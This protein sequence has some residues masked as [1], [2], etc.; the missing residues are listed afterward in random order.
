[1]KFEFSFLIIFILTTEI[2]TQNNS[3]LEKTQISTVGTIEQIGQWN[4]TG[5][6][7]SLYISNNLAFITNNNKLEIIDISLPSSPQ[8]ISEKTLSSA[9]ICEDIVG[10]S[11]KIFL[12]NNRTI[13]AFDISDPNNPDSVA[14]I[15]LDAIISDLFISNNFLY[16]IAS[17]DFYILDISTNNTINILAK[18]SLPE[19]SLG[20]TRFDVKENLAFIA[21]W[22][23]GIFIVD[24]EDSQNP[25]LQGRFLENSYFVF[26]EGSQAYVADFENLYILDITDTM[27]PSILLEKNVNGIRND[28]IA[29]EKFLYVSTNE[30]LVIYDKEDLNFIKSYS[31]NDVGERIQIENGLIF[32]ANNEEGL[33]ILKYNDPTSA[34]KTDE[35]PK[36]FELEQNYPNPFNSST[37]IS[38]QV[39]IQSKVELGIYDIIGNKISEPVNE[40]KSAGTYKIE[41]NANNLASG[42]YFYR[43][44]TSNGFTTSK[45]LILIK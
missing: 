12:A 10:N 39:P 5:Q 45:K 32:I 16:V 42:I 37:V 20:L 3:L 33:K 23:E 17:Y 18:L 25:K 27:L 6:T 29:D 2:F 41:F 14:S 8:L 21:S 35:L 9:F 43:L 30:E 28:L 7:T 44:K 4:S 34:I 19:S 13:Y 11:N 36:T 26:V 38:Y 40:Y 15:K 24:I 22:A 1:M 31:L